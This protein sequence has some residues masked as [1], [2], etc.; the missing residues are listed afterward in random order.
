MTTTMALER[1]VTDSLGFRLEVEIHHGRFNESRGRHISY[2]DENGVVDPTAPHKIYLREGMPDSELAEVCAHEAYHLFYCLREHMTADEE[3]Q[4]EVFGHLVKRLYGVA[5][6]RERE[7]QAKVIA[8]LKASSRIRVDA[9]WLARIFHETYERLAPAFG[10]KTR[11]DTREF[12][13]NSKNGRLMLAT[14]AT[15]VSEIEAALPPPPNEV[16][17]KNEW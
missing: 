16:G 6:I 7:E 1:I 8:R 14:C 5:A 13:P 17:E 3:T 9:E 12:Q 15:V 2:A 4:A 10:Y 11:S